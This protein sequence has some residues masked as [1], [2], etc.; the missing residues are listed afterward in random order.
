VLSCGKIYM[1]TKAGYI[2]YWTSPQQ[3]SSIV[4]LPEGVELD[5]YLGNLVHWR[6][7]VFVL[8]LFHVDMENMHNVW[9]CRMNDGCGHGSSTKR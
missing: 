8:Y 7:E 5:Q 9:L 6:G 2:L 3:D 4:D 1:E